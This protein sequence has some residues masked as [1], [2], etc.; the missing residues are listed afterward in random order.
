[1][2]Q[3]EASKWLDANGFDDPLQWR[4]HTGDSLFDLLLSDEVNDNGVYFAEVVVANEDM[5][6]DTLAGY[7]FDDDLSIIAHLGDRWVH[8]DST[9][10]N[11]EEGLWVEEIYP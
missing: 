10:H 4:T 9:W 2:D 7:V 3:S 11:E 1:M 8:F 5:E 6:S